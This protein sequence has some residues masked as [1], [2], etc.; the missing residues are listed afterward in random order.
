MLTNT[1]LNNK[2]YEHKI[3]PGV[4]VEVLCEGTD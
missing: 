3:P 2:N 1:Y 4:G